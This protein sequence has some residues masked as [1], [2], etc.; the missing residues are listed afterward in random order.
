M[1][2]RNT[3][4]IWEYIIYN[5]LYLALAMIY[6]RNTLF[7]PLEG[8]KR[9]TDG[10][11]AMAA[12]LAVVTAVGVILT[13][14]KRRNMLMVFTNIVWAYAIYF[15]MTFAVYVP[16]ATVIAC[17]IALALS[18]LYAYWVLRDYYRSDEILRWIIPLR[19]CIGATLLSCRTIAAVVLSVLLLGYG[20]GPLLGLPIFQSSSNASAAEPPAGADGPT[21]EENME[22]I[23]LLREDAWAECDLQTKLDV[24]QVVADI[25]AA[26][27]GIPDIKVGAAVLE[28]TTIGHFESKDYDIE[29]NL[30]YLNGAKASLMLHTI[31]H[32][33]YHAYQDRMIAAYNSVDEPLRDLLLFR[34]AAQYDYEF[35]HYITADQGYEDYDNQQ[36][37][38]DADSYADKAVI[39][40]YK[41][42]VIDMNVNGSGE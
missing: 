6:Y 21:V 10:L 7:V 27:L 5:C 29:L 40:Y 11:L 25:E 34:D 17:V 36:C 30:K 24:M 18:A 12:I 26:S 16:Q 14:R 4:P 15:F 2:N 31:C 1:R 28:E 19:Q 37:E 42:L 13:V 22:Y 32:E 41:A 9:D 8:L 39:L 35:N 38:R 3:M 23:R 33:V 20:V